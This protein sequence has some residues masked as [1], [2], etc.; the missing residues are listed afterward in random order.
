MLNTLGEEAAAAVASA[1]NAPPAGGSG[2]AGAEANGEAEDRDGVLKAGVDT[3]GRDDVFGLGDL[4]PPSA[5][6]NGGVFGLLT[7]LSSS[8]FTGRIAIGDFGETGGRGLFSVVSSSSSSSSSDSSLETAFDSGE[9]RVGRVLGRPMP[10]PNGEEVDD[11]P[12]VVGTGAGEGVDGV[13]LVCVGG[14]VVLLFRSTFGDVEDSSSA[15]S[16]GG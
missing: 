16:S 7:E 14:G 1:S 8:N 15:S 5:K 13:C 4:F 6:S 2:L 9:L 12:G 10:N 11:G 3:G